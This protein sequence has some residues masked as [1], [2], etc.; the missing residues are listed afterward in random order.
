[1]KSKKSYPRRLDAS[2]CRKLTEQIRSFNTVGDF[3]AALT[4]EMLTYIGCDQSSSM[5]EIMLGMVE[6]CRVY[7]HELYEKI[8]K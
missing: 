6:M 1:M 4:T 3:K 8:K 2:T 7:N 5:S